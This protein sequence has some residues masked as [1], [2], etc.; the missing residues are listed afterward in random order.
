MVFPHFE[1]H[2]HCHPWQMSINHSNQQ[3][4]LTNRSFQVVDRMVEE[5][6]WRRQ[7]KMHRRVSFLLF[8]VRYY[9]QVQG[10]T[11]RQP[12]SGLLVLKI[13]WSASG[14]RISKF[15]WSASDPD[16]L[17]R[18]DQP[19]GPWIPASRLRGHYLT[20]RKQF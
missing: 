6:P 18:T 14:S 10:L 3:K 1:V 4:Y 9:P 17:V 11:D 13:S 2:F 5:L 7:S 19:F 15:S 12:R 8:S 16:L 20:L